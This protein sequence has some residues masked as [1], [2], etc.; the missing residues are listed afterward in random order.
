VRVTRIIRRILKILAG[1]ILPPVGAV[2]IL[3]GAMWLD[4]RSDTALP[5]PTGPYAVGRTTFDLAP[6]SGTPTELV[7][8]MWYPAAGV[9]AASTEY[10]P[11]KWRAAIGKYRGTFINSFLNRD[12]S[13]V[14]AHSSADSPISYAE[15]RFPVVLMR[16]GGSSLTAEYAV[17][18]EDLA[19]HG[20]VVVGFD[21][22]F[23]TQVV[24]LQD[25]RVIA[26][27]PENDPDQF[28]GDDLRR[29]AERLLEAWT[30]DTAFLLDYLAQ[31]D[32]NDPAGRF[33]GH[34]D[35]NHVGM[36]GHSLGGATA[37]QFCHVDPRCKTGIDVD[38]LALGGVVHDGLSKPFMFLMSDHSRDA[39]D[40]AEAAR[41][42]ADLQGI[43][44]RLPADERAAIEIRGANHYGFSDGAV[45][46][47]P[48]LQRLLSMVGIIGMD[49]RRQ[50]AITAA[51][52][53]GWFD[54]QLKGAPATTLDK[55]AAIYPE[56]QQTNWMR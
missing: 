52:V 16:P 27:T 10:L 1:L 36:F 21:A 3:L 23:R 37:L 2:G 42:K 22:P 53:H 28:S 11:Y 5:M 50:L 56:A 8:W 26:R 51:Y 18:A 48:R 29:V 41:I 44:S 9:S 12:L 25:G 49:G 54:V 24:A 20:Y 35:M 7:V 55:L 46:R 38:G 19:S 32:A 40:P 14:V 4:H 33:T 13:R 45:L 39:S 31:L 17:L 34:L 6:R 30:S 47:S 43:Y 15:P